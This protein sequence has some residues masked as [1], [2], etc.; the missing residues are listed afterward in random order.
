MTTVSPGAVSEDNRP[1]LRDYI[2]AKAGQGQSPKG[3]PHLFKATAAD[4]AGRLDFITG[5]FSPLT[6][7]P[8]HLH[9]EQEDSLYILDGILTVQV[10]DAVFDIGPG[11]FLSVPPG[12]AHTFDNL[13]NEGKTVWVVN[14]MAPG[15][16]FDMFAEMAEVEP[17]P[18]Q[19]EAVR[20]V[21]EHHGTVFLGPPLRVRL[22]LE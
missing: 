13:H 4:T 18:T 9:R 3:S 12:M 21:G 22:G 11:D 5:A 19:A 16:H 20:R 10:G 17:G 6:G 2:L 15:G 14:V 1:R 7:P 8:L